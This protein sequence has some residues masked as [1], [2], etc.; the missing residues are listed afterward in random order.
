MIKITD[1][2]MESLKLAI[3]MV[4]DGALKKAEQDEPGFHISVY[5]VGLI[6]R[7]DI[8]EDA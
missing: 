1:H 4:G 3:Q 8:K 5:K 7:I 2:F 6:V